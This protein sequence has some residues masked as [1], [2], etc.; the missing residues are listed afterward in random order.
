[1]LTGALQSR[2]FSGRTSTARVLTAPQSSRHLIPDILCFAIPFSSAWN[3]KFIGE[4]PLGEIM[5]LFLL[6]ICLINYNKRIW[7]PLNRSIYI[8]MGFWLLGQVVSDLYRHSKFTNAA[9]GVAGIIFFALDLIVLTTIINYKPRRILMFALG[10]AP[11]HMIIYLF[12]PSGWG[13]EQADVVWKTTWGPFV[14][15][16][17]L[18]VCCYMTRLKRYNVVMLL[19]TALIAINLLEN[20]R[21]AALILTLTLVLSVP[22]P[23]TL[24]QKKVDYKG[25]R[26]F[27]TR[28]LIMV[29]L[30]SIGMTALAM[31]Y[32][33]TASMGML[34]DVAQSKYE[35]QS[36]GKFGVLI[37]GRPETLVSLK[38][39]AENPFIGHGSWAE[40]PKYSQMLLDELW[41]NG[42]AMDQADLP[43]LIEGSFLIPTHSHIF[44]AWVWAGILGAAFWIFFLIFVARGFSALIR[45][46]PWLA[47]YMAYT[48]SL[49]LWDVF[50]SPFASY[51]RITVSLLVVIVL[52]LLTEDKKQTEILRLKFMKTYRKTISVVFQ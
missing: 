13:G 50:F 6:P 1:M 52:Y 47:P 49:A 27:D 20:F 7:T 31:T 2:S 28:I 37:G 29:L 15:T 51:R 24:Q 39:I 18:L 40:D 45:V 17:T 42:Y 9:K 23:D 3:V 41:E 48:L 38:A 44:G 32:S 35:S 8:M 19:I 16:T 5:V 14:N 22:L 33:Y 10:V 26:P 36:R 21:S 11:M 25:R 12:S 4:L 34:G 30:G 43:R 46:R